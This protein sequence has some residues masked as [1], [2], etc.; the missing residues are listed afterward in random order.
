M[1]RWLRRLL[2][3][4]LLLALIVSAPI[5]WIE[6]EGCAVRRRSQRGPRAPLVDDRDY[7]RREADSYLFVPQWHI[8]YAY[9]DLAGVLQQGNERVRLRPAD[10]RVLAEPVP[11][12]RRGDR[13]RAR[14]QGYEVML[15]TIG[16]S[17]TAEL[18]L[19]GAYE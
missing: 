6:E 8:V 4:L 12:D 17:F 7:A 14:G 2:G 15:Y 3:V 10:R 1:F 19:K 5:L 13:P 16:W 18:A 11:P 9:E